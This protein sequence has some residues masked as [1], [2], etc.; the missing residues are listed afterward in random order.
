MRSKDEALSR[1]PAAPI[2]VRVK[3]LEWVGNSKGGWYGNVAPGTGLPHYRV[4]GT[5]WW[6]PADHERYL[7]D[8]EAEA[9]AAAQADY[10]ARILAA[11]ELPPQGSGMP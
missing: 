10:E 1:R 6:R 5:R 3:A 9:K 4:V 2:G 7:C 11:L 8:S